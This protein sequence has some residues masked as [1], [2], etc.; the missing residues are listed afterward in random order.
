MLTT[1]GMSAP[2]TAA[3]RCT[4]MII[5]MPVIAISATSPFVSGDPMK[6]QPSH[7]ATSSAIDV[8]RVTRR[9]QQRFAG[10]RALQFAER[11]D[12]TGERDRA[13]EYAEEDL[14]QMDRPFRAGELDVGID[15]ARDADQHRGEPD[16]A[17][18][19]RHELRH[20]RHFD[21]RGDRTRRSRRRSPSPESARRARRRACRRP[22]RRS[23][24]PCRARRR[25][26]RAA[27]SPA[28]SS[29][30]RLRMKS[31]AAP[32]YETVM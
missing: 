26:C 9:Q 29:P 24:S 27:R 11:D 16:E 6:L 4:P 28:C 20:L 17:V 32:R 14:D 23:R 12:R 3:T 21:A 15:V 13:D 25:C 22:S 2:P 8:Q 1:T 18:Q 19:H 5:A 30:P 10:Q 7:N 31:I